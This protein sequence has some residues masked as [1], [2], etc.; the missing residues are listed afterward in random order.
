MKLETAGLHWRLDRSQVFLNHGS[1]GAVPLEVEQERRRWL[2]QLELDPVGFLV[3]QLPEAL[4]QARSALAQFLGAAPA[5]AQGLAFVPSTTYGLNELI[6]Q[7]QLPEGSRVLLGMDAYNATANIVEFW[8]EQRGWQVLRA[9]WPLPLSCCSELLEAYRSELRKGVA[10]WVIDHIT[11]PTAM[12]QPLEQLIPMARAHG[13]AVIVDGAHGPGSLPINLTSLAGLGL[14][15]Y[16]GNLHKWL[17]CPKGSAFL[18]VREALRQQLRPLVISHGANAPVGSEGRFRLEH[19]WLGTNDPSGYLCLPKA[20]ALLGL[21]TPSDQEKQLKQR[22]Q[23]L[24]PARQAL[25]EALGSAN[26]GALVPE[27]QVAS[28]VAVELANCDPDITYKYFR[29]AGIQIPIIPLRP[30]RKQ[31]RCFLRLSW[32]NYNTISDLKYLIE[33]CKGLP[34]I[35]AA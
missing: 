16:V 8:A 17:C 22:R 12:G 14:D 6:S 10:L 25:M 2:D 32:F 27:G 18:W 9:Q 26:A 33:I 21:A 4:G 7:W 1:F 34:V 3:E 30:H 15:A 5:E 20:L 23:M 29:N 31:E 13:A 35:K 19:D 24:L 28:M 11:S